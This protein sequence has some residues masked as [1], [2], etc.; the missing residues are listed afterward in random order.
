M[1]QVVLSA[2]KAGIN[3]MR[4]KGGA[5]PASLYDLLNGW[6]RQD[7]SIE[8]RDGTVEV[9]TLPAGTKGLC[10]FNGGFVVFSHQ[11]TTGLPAGYAC[12]VLVNPN[13]ATQALTEIHFAAPMMGALYVVAEFANGEVFHYWLQGSGTSGAT[14]EADTVYSEGD[15]ILPT[16]PNGL[17]Y[18]AVR[19]T[20]PNPVWA[21][22]VKRAVDDKVE[23]TVANDY[24][25]TVIDTLGDNPVSGE[26]EPDWT[27][28]EG[29]KVYEDTSIT[30]KSATPT[31]SDLSKLNRSTL[32]RYGDRT[33]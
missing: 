24:Y 8:S 19:L 33:K 7:G 27:A 6:V 12:E 17:A 22:G 29:A 9:A 28:S 23:P 3:R 5:D 16:T 4:T 20:A 21:A 18:Q 31:G 2:L 1:S 14:W 13:D 15:L 11:V 10:A 30:P 26:S 25:Y 32:D